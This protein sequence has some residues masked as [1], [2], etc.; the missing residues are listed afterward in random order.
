MIWL[1]SDPELLDVWHNFLKD[2][3]CNHIFF[4]CIR[5]F[6]FA[7]LS[8]F[9]FWLKLKMSKKIKVLSFRL[10]S[11]WEHKVFNLLLLDLFCRDRKLV[12]QSKVDFEQRIRSS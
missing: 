1:H 5:I 2:R 3:R 12:F 6:F 8:F 10:A 9:F 7:L 4:L 11:W